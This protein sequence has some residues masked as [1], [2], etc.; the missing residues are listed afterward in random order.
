MV[1]DGIS[2][3][4][5]WVVVKSDWSFHYSTTVYSLSV[6][7]LDIKRYLSNTEM[8]NFILVL[9]AVLTVN[10]ATPHAEGQDYD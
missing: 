10:K 8:F 6:K 2:G 9:V 3:S 7:W 1:A 5:D 4:V